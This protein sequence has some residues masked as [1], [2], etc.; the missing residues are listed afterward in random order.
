SEFP[1]HLMTHIQRL[2]QDPN[3]R[4]VMH[5]HPTNLVAMSFTLPL[6]EKLFSRI[7]WKMQA[8][9]IVVFPEGIGVLPYMT[10]GTNEIGQATAQKM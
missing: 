2:K 4:V 8:E 5:C 10:P 1:S 7:L 6:E 9:S 3:Q